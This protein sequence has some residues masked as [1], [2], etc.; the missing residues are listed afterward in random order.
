VGGVDV[1]TQ[2]DA[3]I[4]ERELCLRH[5]LGE[6]VREVAG[7]RLVDGG[8]AGRVACQAR[9]LQRRRDELVVVVAGHH[10]DGLAGDR[11]PQAAQHGRDVRHDRG[12]EPL[13]QL[14]QI[15]EEDDAV[16]GPERGGEPLERLRTPGDVRLHGG[17]E[18]QIGDDR[19]R[20]GP[21]LRRG[22]ATLILD[23][24]RVSVFCRHNRFTA[25]CPICSK[26]T[27]LD[28]S[29]PAERRRPA[30][31]AGSAAKSKPV[32]G[33]GAFSGPNVAGEARHDEDGK[34]TVVRLEKVPGG[35][36]LGEWHGSSLAPRA[37]V[38]PAGELVD[39]VSRSAEALQSRDASALAASL[40]GDADPSAG[41]DAGVSKGRSGD[42]KEELRIERLDDGRVRV[43]RWVSRPAAGWEL[44]DAPPMLP[45]KRY[46]EALGDAVRR[47][48]LTP[49]AQ[50]RTS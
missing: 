47:G 30:R 17:P 40:A 37:P 13:A 25:E 9:P 33:T 19:G 23:G 16:G 1:L 5:E 36:R 2:P 11:R 12:R 18:V 14:Q 15:A 21:H 6:A 32:G 41:G 45:A 50:A 4:R 22:P 3:G 42:F 38:L 39:L 48:V 24:P 44:Q 35:V 43:A 49:S 46:A 7:R 10:D 27:V 8:Q 31:R 20:H 34:L 29:R 26:G 28:S